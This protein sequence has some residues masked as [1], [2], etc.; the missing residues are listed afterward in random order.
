[1]IDQ[2]RAQCLPQFLEVA[3]RRLARILELAGRGQ[4]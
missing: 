4:P 2:L 1:M 3:D